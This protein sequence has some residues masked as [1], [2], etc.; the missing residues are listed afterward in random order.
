MLCLEH[1]QKIYP[2]GEVLK[3]INWEVK[4]GKSTQLKI[5]AGAVEPTAGHI[6]KPSHFKVGYLS[7]EFAVDL[8]NTVKNE[9]W[10]VFTEANQI[11]AQK[12]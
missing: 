9:F 6:V 10:L 5:I 4:A 1:I 8:A 3:E 2:T 12:C 7:Q 11:Q